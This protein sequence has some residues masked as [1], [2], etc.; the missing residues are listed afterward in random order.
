MMLL[1]IPLLLICKRSRQSPNKRQKDTAEFIVTDE[2]LFQEEDNVYANK[3]MLDEALGPNRTVDREIDDTDILHY[4]NLNFSKLQAKVA[5]QGEGEGE[6]RGVASKPAEYAVIRLHSTGS[7]EGGAGKKEA[8][9]ALEQG[10]HA[11]DHGAKVLEE[12]QAGHKSDGE[13]EVAKDSALPKL[14]G[15]TNSALSV[16]EST[17]AP[18]G[19]SE[20]HNTA[21][22]TVDEVTLLSE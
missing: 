4:A 19:Q 13:E 3:A 15:M 20:Q 22:T 21:E 16:Q 17:E 18:L 11:E 2:A 6:I 8:N 5:K 9:P 14:Q 10:D 1:C 12:T 7:I